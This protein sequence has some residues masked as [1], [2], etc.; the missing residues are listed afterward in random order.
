MA[1]SLSNRLFDHRAY[2]IS[3]DY[4]STGEEDLTSEVILGVNDT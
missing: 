4:K 2:P 3:V 1:L